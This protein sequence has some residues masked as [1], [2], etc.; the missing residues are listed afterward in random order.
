MTREEMVAVFEEVTMAEMYE[1]I[2]R[3]FDGRE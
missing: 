2:V 1:E 3:Q